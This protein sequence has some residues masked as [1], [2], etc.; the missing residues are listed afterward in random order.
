MNP[1]NATNEEVSDD[2]DMDF[3][4]EDYLEYGFFFLDEEP[5]SEEDLDSD[6]FDTDEEVE[7]ELEGL[8]NE[9]DIA[10]F[11]AVLAH[12]QA[13]AIKAEHEAA[14]E[15]KKHKQ[16]YT[17]GNSVHTKRQHAQKRRELAATGQ[18]L[19]SSMFTKKVTEST[20][21]EENEAPP[22]PD[23]IEIPDDLDSNSLDKG[24]DEFEAS[25]KQLFPGEHEVS[26]L[27]HEIFE[28]NLTRLN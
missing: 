18:K 23:A 9:A 5:T 19:I 11:N 4:D 22:G 25:L 13:M 6:G 28:P 10:H 12:A 8:E 3:E 14:G 7:D 1:Q 21:M 17:A 2:E 26:S 16:H 24:D 15:K 20:L 27:K